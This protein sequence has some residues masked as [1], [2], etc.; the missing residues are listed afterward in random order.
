MLLV[1]H[2]RALQDRHHS[3]PR[4][5]PTGEPSRGAAIHAGDPAARAHV[6]PGM[7]VDDAAAVERVDGGRA[8]DSAA[9]VQRR[10]GHAGAGGD[11]GGRGDG[12]LCARGVE[13]EEAADRAAS[14][15][16]A[17]RVVLCTFDVPPPSLSQRHCGADADG[18]LKAGCIVTARLVMVI[19]A[20]IVSSAGSYSAVW[21]CA[22]IAY[23][24]RSN[25]TMLSLYPSCGSYF[26]GTNPWQE[27][28]VHADMAGKVEEVGAALNVSFGMACWVALALHAI[29]IEIYVS[30]RLFALS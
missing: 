24:L 28:A 4:E 29:G 5:H 1:H 13:C 10:V 3:A 20:S 21:P 17:E 16:D 15:V 26:D 7:R 27:A 14:G 6:P 12:V 19:A 23:A 25:E 30:L 9:G 11:A 2:L 8:G 22:K 18:I